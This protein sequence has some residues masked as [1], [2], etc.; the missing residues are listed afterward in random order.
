MT[1]NPTQTRNAKGAPMAGAWKA[2]N[3]RGGAIDTSNQSSA[4]PLR[5][6]ETDRQSVRR[7]QE[8]IRGQVRAKFGNSVDGDEVFSQV[9]EEATKM[10][11]DGKMR[12]ITSN[13]G[14]LRVI[15]SRKAIDIAYP[16]Q[17]S[18]T[19]TGKIKLIQRR[20]ELESELGR[21]LSPKEYEALADQIRLA[22]PPKRR[23]KIGYHLD[24]ETTLTLDKPIGD[25][26][27]TFG[28]LMEAQEKTDTSGVW[29]ATERA[30]H[31]HEGV[32]PLSAEQVRGE[33]WRFA[34]MSNPSVPQPVRIPQQDADR[35]A[36][37]AERI[38]IDW[39]VRAYEDDNIASDSA[40]S[41]FAPF[42]GVQG[43]T[44]AQREAVIDVLSRNGGYSNQLWSVALEQ[45]RK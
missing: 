12:D 41:L 18:E 19:R 9:M 4:G 17:S 24:D 36:A 42:G 38:G 22:E 16:G 13:I 40:E 2:D 32:T 35:A 37:D 6:S 26:S 33:Y 7:L 1:F 5:I 23:P 20:Q 30:M 15:A 27:V 28:E 44:D 39:M 10:L 29:G 14:K 21:S 25:G 31:G 11:R 8:L 43:T 34:A 3:Q 45:A